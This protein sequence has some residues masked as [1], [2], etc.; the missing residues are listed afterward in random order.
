MLILPTFPRVVL[1]G[2]KPYVSNFDQMATA[3]DGML[4]AQ[5]SNRTKSK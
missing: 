4:A 1:E 3:K 2:F 5:Q